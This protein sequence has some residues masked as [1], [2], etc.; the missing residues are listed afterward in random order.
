[1]W[2]TPSLYEQRSQ[3]PGISPY[4][5][6]RWA[7]LAWFRAWPWSVPASL[8][9]RNNFGYLRSQQLA[10]QVPGSPV[11]GTVYAS[12]FSFRR[13]RSF[14]GSSRASFVDSK[15]YIHRI[16]APYRW[17][18]GVRGNGAPYPVICWEE[19][20][21][22]RDPAIAP[23]DLPPFSLD[24]YKH[25]LVLGERL[26]P[27]IL[28]GVV[29]NFLASSPGSFDGHCTGTRAIYPLPEVLPPVPTRDGKFIFRR[30]SD[31]DDGS[32]EDGVGRS[33]AFVL[34][35]FHQSDTIKQD[36]I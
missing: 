8:R 9:E 23:R 33:S 14:V 4:S 13:D 29:A 5:C 36:D 32:S 30:G 34:R 3:K 11:T 20:K 24:S 21:R 19:R 18:H 16:G 10:P 26:R 15:F 22:T 6:E 2:E 31:V 12:A 1:M 27:S 17:C 25:C 35:I 28:M 7:G